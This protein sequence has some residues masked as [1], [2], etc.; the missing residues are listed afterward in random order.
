MEA[1]NSFKVLREI[2]SGVESFLQSKYPGGRP[3]NKEQQQAQRA[4]IEAKKKAELDFLRNIVNS[5]SNKEQ[6]GEGKSVRR[7]EKE[8]ISARLNF[9][10]LCLFIGFEAAEK[11]TTLTH[12][13]RLGIPAKRNKSIIELIGAQK[14]AI[15]RDK[16]FRFVFLQNNLSSQWRKRLS[17]TYPKTVKP[18]KGQEMADK[19]AHALFFGKIPVLANVLHAPK[20]QKDAAKH[21]KIPASYVCNLSGSDAYAQIKKELE[22]PTIYTNWK[23]YIRGIATAKIVF[24]DRAQ[25]ESF[26]FALFWALSDVERIKNLDN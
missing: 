8:R 6:T 24:I 26:E 18:G 7:A 12:R 2:L 4:R 16:N 11:L 19:L 17:I 21:F 22:S 5:T 25:V 13:T 20:K 3:A 23:D 14:E 9:A 15:L 10:V 1:E